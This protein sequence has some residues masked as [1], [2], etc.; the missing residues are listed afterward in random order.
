MNNGIK[1]LKEFRDWFEIQVESDLNDL[2]TRHHFKKLDG[3]VDLIE[4][5]FQE[6]PKVTASGTTMPSFPTAVLKEIVPALKTITTAIEKKELAEKK[7]CNSN[8]M[9]KGILKE[10]REVNK[11]QT[12]VLFSVLKDVASAIKNLPKPQDVTV[13][14]KDMPEAMLERVAKSIEAISVS[15]NQKVFI[16]S[17]VEPKLSLWKR[18]KKW[19]SG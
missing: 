15:A 13:V 5:D 16:E 2:L 14:Q 3:I 12:D 19:F 9:F 6:A 8:E 4:Q 17:P 10:F 18:I 1:Q 7:P 11:T